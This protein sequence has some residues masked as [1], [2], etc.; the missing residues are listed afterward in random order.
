MTYRD[1]MFGAIVFKVKSL[2]FFNKLQN[3]KYLN[4]SINKTNNKMQIFLKEYNCVLE[5]VI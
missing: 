4:S 5:F 3:D 1:S 2:E